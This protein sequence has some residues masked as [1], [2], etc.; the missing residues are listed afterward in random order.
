[1]RS[2]LVLSFALALSSMATVAR[3]QSADLADG[4]T[5]GTYLRLGAGSLTP[6]NPQGSLRDWKRGSTFSLIYEN[7]G[8]GSGGVGTLG[9]GLAVDYGRLPFDAA[10]FTSEFT[11]FNGGKVTSADASSATE[12]SIATTLRVRIPAPYIMPSI[13]VSFGYLDFKPSTVHFTATSGSGTATQQHRRGASLAIG[14]GLDKHIFDRFGVFGEALY[15]YGFTSLG[16][17]IANPGG[18]C[19]TNGCD[20]LKNT[21]LGTLRGG[22]RLQVGR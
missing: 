6:I 20:V 7:W 11:P 18:T 2:R 10:Q 17:G 5:A 1:M 21:V 9:L 4:L 13:L 8:A 3:A 12:F 19:T 22:L 14:G 15:T 16:R